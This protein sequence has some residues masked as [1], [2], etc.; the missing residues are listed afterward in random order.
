MQKRA[1]SFILTERDYVETL[2]KT[3]DAVVNR[4]FPKN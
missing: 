4:L 3:F 2:L 1:L